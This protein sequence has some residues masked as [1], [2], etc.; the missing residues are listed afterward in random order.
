MITAARKPVRLCF[1]RPVWRGLSF[2]VVVGCAGNVKRHERR[3]RVA[4]ISH[5]HNPVRPPGN[6]S[7]QAL[8]CPLCAKAVLLVAGEDPNVTFERH[9]RDGCDTD[10]YR[11]V[12]DKARC[13]VKGCSE[14]L[15]FSN[16]HVCKSCALKAR[17]PARGATLCHAHTST[18][19]PSRR[20]R[21]PRPP[22]EWL[23]LR[24]CPPPRRH[25]RVRTAPFTTPPRRSISLS[26]RVSVSCE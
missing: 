5:P 9:Q 19:V 14:K 17:S 4:P 2:V 10:N 13:P 26:L 7:T 21:R 22:S 15:T 12:N 11:R 24:A 18:R 25:V 1:R 23:T 20:L 8:V 16:T 3:P 6:K